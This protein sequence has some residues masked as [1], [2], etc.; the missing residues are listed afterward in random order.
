MVVVDGDDF[1]PAGESEG[2]NSVRAD[3][4]C[5]ASDEY[6]LEGAEMW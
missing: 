4:T 1:E 6:S 2:E 3:V 5:A